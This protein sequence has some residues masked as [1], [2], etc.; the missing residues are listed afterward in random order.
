MDCKYFWICLWCSCRCSCAMLH[1]LV[2][3]WVHLHKP[4]LCGQGK[5]LK[6]QFSLQYSPDSSPFFIPFVP[7][8]LSLCLLLS[9]F[10]LKDPSVLIR[11]FLGSR[12]IQWVFLLPSHFLN[13]S[14]TLS[15]SFLLASHYLPLAHLK[16]LSPLS[17]LPLSSPKLGHF[18]YRCKTVRFSQDMRRGRRVTAEETETTILKINK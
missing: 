15:Y 11:R 6:A 8:S 17:S 14:F 18:I 12:W 4:I 10:A 9:P 1:N 7:L 3:L 16:P 13:Q 5:T 2:S